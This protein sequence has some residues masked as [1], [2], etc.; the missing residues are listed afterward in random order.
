MKVCSVC[1]SS[2]IQV[3]LPAWFNPNTWEQVGTDDDADVMSTYCGKCDESRNGD[4]MKEA[5]E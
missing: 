2:E 5:R 3:T 1:G 4:W